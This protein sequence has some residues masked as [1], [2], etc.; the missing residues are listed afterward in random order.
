LNIFL[1]IFNAKVVE[2]F[3]HLR[4]FPTH[5]TSILNFTYS[6][7]YFSILHTNFYKI[8]HIPLSVLQYVLLKYYKIFIFYNIFSRNLLPRWNSFITSNPTPE[9]LHHQQPKSIA[10]PMPKVGKPSSPNPETHGHRI[11]PTSAH[12]HHKPMPANPYPQTQ[13]TTNPRRQLFLKQKAK[14]K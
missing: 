12:N 4:A 8:P 11:P 14:K 1:F 7:S 5:F 9:L 13:A 3:C 10:H 2:D 6:K